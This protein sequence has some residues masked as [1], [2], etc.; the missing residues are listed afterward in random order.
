ME[1]RKTFEGGSLTF[2][3]K[4]RRE[5]WEVEAGLPGDDLGGLNA[6]AGADAGFGDGDAAGWDR[7]EVD[8][9]I[10]QHL[11]G[12]II[13][14]GG[15]T[16]REIE[17]SYSVSISV[18]QS[19]KELGY[20]RIRATGDAT[21]LQAA[22]DHM[23]ESLARA[24][25]G[26]GDSSDP[27]ATGPFL[28][29]S[30]P[31]PVVDS[32]L[33]GALEDMHIEQRLVGWLLG[34]GGAVIREIELSSGCKISI[35][36]ETKHLGF[37]KVQV[38]GSVH[39]R[40]H[41][42]QLISESI[43]R[44]DSFSAEAAEEVEVG[45][46][47]IGASYASTFGSSGGGVGASRILEEGMMV[48]QKWVGWLI[49]RG[50]GVTREIE[51]ETMAKIRID[52]STKHLG[53][54]TIQIQGNRSEVEMAKSR[55]AAS[56]QKVGAAPLS[57]GHGGGGGG[58]GGVG[59]RA[60]VGGPG[61]QQV[62]I[63]QHLIGW[64]LGRGGGM[65]KEIEAASGA[66]ISLNQETKE[67]GYSVATIKGDP[68]AVSKAQEAIAETLSRVGG[69]APTAAEAYNGGAVESSMKTSRSLPPLVAPQAYNGSSG[70]NRDPSLTNL[71]PAL[72]LAVESI[73]NAVGQPH[74]AR[75]LGGVL[76]QAGVTKPVN[77][78][79]A[80]P[81]RNPSHRPMHQSMQGHGHDA[82]V[83]LQLEQK[84]VGWLLGGKGKTVKA[85]EAESGAKISID[86]STKEYG[87]SV[88]KLSGSPDAI[89]LAQERIQASLALV[90]PGGSTTPALIPM[91]GGAEA[92]FADA[93]YVGQGDVPRMSGDAVDAGEVSEGDMEVDQKLVG[94]LLGKSGVVLKEI[95]QQSGA[96]VTIDQSTKELG[97]SIVRVRGGYH[98]CAA[99]RA[100]IQDK[101][102]QAGPPASMSGAGFGSMLS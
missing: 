23:N 58:G 47:P 5:A 97:Y 85:I 90:I 69:S 101:I 20:S 37:S 59:G 3:D 49:G 100:L 4:R 77:Q 62:Q 84:W 65:I 14:R 92:S 35:N 46:L 83:E 102:T 50:G 82:P 80:E 89:R 12:W 99:A 26:P 7:T 98:E 51:Q 74:L 73:A 79:A 93:F 17:Q 87:Y 63:E 36:Q 54:S 28:L 34:K 1:K 10:E 76:K 13:G 40:Q 81:L 21:A 32:T 78:S 86:Q 29:E 9:F 44:A 48:E 71:D 25:A 72:A 43:E 8:Y 24:V 61:T 45:A 2:G 41:A 53:Y 55:I 39:Q 19:T 30:P 64:L 68:D 67:L 16:L 57:T 22:C 15:A 11:V 70:R 31:A 33:Q 52:Q 96:R 60:S 27:S 88:L 42:R 95:E 94:W 75:Q 91:G 6:E 18:D 66:R 56:L 38:H